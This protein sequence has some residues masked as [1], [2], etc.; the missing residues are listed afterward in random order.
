MLC[1]ST[2]AVLRAARRAT[3]CR[4]AGS[5]PIIVMPLLLLLLLLPPPQGRT[6]LDLV[7]A[8]KRHYV[9][10]D[11]PLE[12]GEVRRAGWGWL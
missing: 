10:S 3:L 1:G 8:L 2:C 12:D 7:S 4:A 11:N 5:L 9:K 6:I